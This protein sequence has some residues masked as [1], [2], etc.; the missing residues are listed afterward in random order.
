MQFESLRSQSALTPLQLIGIRP[1]Q[2]ERN[3][4]DSQRRLTHLRCQQVHLSLG[5]EI[6][7]GEIESRS[8][9][10]LLN[11]PAKRRKTDG[12]LFILPPPHYHSPL[13][14]RTHLPLDLNG[15]LEL[16]LL[17]LQ[18][19]LAKPHT[20]QRSASR[21][22]KRCRPAHAPRLQALPLSERAGV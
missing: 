22:Q 17:Q 7:I 10:L 2:D 5:R 18:L 1:I 11:P 6:V 20:P 21:P 13:R 15:V 12:A 14:L 8:F 9:S 16:P 3:R 19:R 4:L